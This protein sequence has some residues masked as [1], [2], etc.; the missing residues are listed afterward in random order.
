[1]RAVIRRNVRFRSKADMC[2]AKRYVRF[3]SNSD[4]ESVHKCPCI[5][6]VNVCRRQSPCSI[7]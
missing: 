3:Y 7:A 2:S 6:N 4:R 5:V 1:M